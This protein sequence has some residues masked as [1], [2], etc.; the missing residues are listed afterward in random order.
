MKLF[1][2]SLKAKFLKVQY[3]LLFKEYSS[4][5]QYKIRWQRYL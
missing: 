4:Q 3:W 5:T 2:L 1:F